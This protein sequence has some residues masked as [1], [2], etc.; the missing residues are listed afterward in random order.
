M[1]T[2]YFILSKPATASPQDASNDQIVYLNTRQTFLLPQV[3]LEYYS[4]HGL[5]ER[6]LMEWCL[7]FLQPDR[8]FLDIGAHTGTY[9]ISFANK[10]SAVHAFE[11]QKATYYALCGGIALSDLSNK[12][13]AH[14]FGLGSPEQVGEQQ[15]NI[16]SN[17]GGGSTMHSSGDDVLRT[18]RIEIRTLDSL[19]IKDVG[20]I[21]MDVEENELFVLKGAQQTLENSGFPPILFE[22]NRENRELFRY[23][24]ETM[25]YSI[26]SIRGAANMFLATKS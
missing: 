25:N 7:Q 5:F 15:L 21:K 2:P 9:A 18:E 12:I 6:Q 24:H 22:C 26:I 11:P 8:V 10:C 13:T 4:K 3:N 14:P 23:I 17:D 1:S 19:D 16:V 20:F